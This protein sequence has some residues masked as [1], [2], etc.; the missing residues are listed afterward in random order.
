MKLT[1]EEIAA[2]RRRVKSLVASST[3]RLSEGHDRLIN[4]PA[5]T[6]AFT[7]ASQ[8]M[9]LAE[10]WDGDRGELEVRL[11]EAEAHI[12][13]GFAAA[14]ALVSAF[15]A[16][17]GSAFGRTSGLPVI[18]DGTTECHKCG[19]P[20]TLFSA[21]SDA[22]YLKMAAG[23][24]TLLFIMHKKC[25][26]SAKRSQPSD[27]GPRIVRISEEEWAPLFTAKTVLSS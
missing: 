4:S 8:A 13:K 3:S 19:H 2:V 6:G 24:D 21:S 22:A 25:W 9:K 7:D 11:K 5:H 26:G 1:D 10:G 20:V 18:E 16:G 14:D 12:V 23:R 27:G 15:P 17:S